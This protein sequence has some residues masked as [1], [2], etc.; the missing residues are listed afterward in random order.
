MKY[1]YGSSK[2]WPAGQRGVAPVSAL[3]APQANAVRG[4]P[5]ALVGEMEGKN[6]RELVG[7]DPEHFRKRRDLGLPLAGVEAFQEAFRS[8]LWRGTSRSG[9][10]SS[11]ATSAKPASRVSSMTRLPVGSAPPDESG[12]PVPPPSNAMRAPGITLGVRTASSQVRPDG[13]TFALRSVESTVPSASAASAKSGKA[14][15]AEVTDA[16]MSERAE[17]VMLNK[18]EFILDAVHAL[19]NIVT[20]MQRHQQKKRSLMGRL[21]IASRFFVATTDLAPLPSG[22]LSSGPRG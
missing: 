22:E 15:R 20:R 8:N 12:C 6:R 14:T 5:E 10:G 21:G 13:D 1:N 18:G 19:D 17:C 7:F 16:A 2:W 4:R 3:R 11:T 9:P